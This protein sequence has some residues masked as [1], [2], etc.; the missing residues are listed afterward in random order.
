MTGKTRETHDVMIYSQ[1]PYATVAVDGK[2][3]DGIRSVTFRAEAGRPCSVMI[4]FMANHVT[5]KGTAKVEGMEH[6]E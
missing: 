3:I 2:K 5:I 4:E 1:S 6:V